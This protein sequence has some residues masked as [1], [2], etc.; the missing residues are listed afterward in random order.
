MVARGA[1]HPRSSRP[2]SIA[3]VDDTPAGGGA[4]MVL[5]CDVLA[6]A[7][8]ERGRRPPD[9]RADPARQAAH[10]GPRPR[11]GGGPGG[12]PA[13]R[14]VRGVRRADLRG[15]RRRAGVD[16]RL[17]PVGRR[18][19]RDGPARRLHSAAPRRNG[20]GLQRRGGELR[21]RGFSNIRIIPDPSNGKDA[22]SPKCCDRGIMRGSRRGDK[23][24]HPTTHG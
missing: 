1:Q 3:R 19:W 15:A 14:P 9:A 24:G 12:D 17:C 13:V 8:D 20:R 18:A 5:R 10:P 2:T 21:R 23:A 4:G 6:A 11:A 7:L 16:R 22:R